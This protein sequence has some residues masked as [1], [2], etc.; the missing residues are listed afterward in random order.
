M[1]RECSGSRWKVIIIINKLNCI[2]S[3]FKYIE[4]E[5]VKFG[6]VSILYKY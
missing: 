6:S 2:I 3:Y 5:I 1:K 4:I